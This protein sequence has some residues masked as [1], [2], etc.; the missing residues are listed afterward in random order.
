MDF[1]ERHKEVFE[2]YMAAESAEERDNLMKESAR[3]TIDGLAFAIR[4]MITNFDFNEFRYKDE[5]EAAQG[6]WNAL[7][8]LAEKVIED[9][10]VRMCG[11]YG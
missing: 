1:K 4:W 3:I 8:A 11:D 9:G 10:V 6:D 2:K 7:K 5:L